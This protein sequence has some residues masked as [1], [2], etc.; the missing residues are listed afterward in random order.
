MSYQHMLSNVSY[1]LEKFQNILV[2]FKTRGK[3]I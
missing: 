1:Q 3:T 2:K